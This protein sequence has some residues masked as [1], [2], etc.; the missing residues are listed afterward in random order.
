[1]FKSP[2]QHSARKKY[3]GNGYFFSEIVINPLV[4]TEF[5][6]SKMERM[7]QAV[8]CLPSDCWLKGDTSRKVHLRSLR[9][10]SKSHNTKLNWEPGQSSISP[11]H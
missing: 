5:K 6:L 7:Y 4:W 11:G 1:M 8:R 3:R 2:F 9:D 10:V